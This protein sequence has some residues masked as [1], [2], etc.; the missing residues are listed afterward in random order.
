MLHAALSETAGAVAA[1]CRPD[2]A[3]ISRT[4][5][6][7]VTLPT[8]VLSLAPGQAWSGVLTEGDLCFIVGATGGSG[9]REFQTRDG[10][11]EPVIGVAVIPC[12]RQIDR[13]VAA[14]PQVANVTGGEEAVATFL[15]GEHLL[16]VPASDVTNAS[17]CPTRCARGAAASRSATSA[18]SS[19]TT[20]R[21]RS[22]TSPPTCPP[23]AP[24][25]ALVL[26]AGAQRFGL[27]VSELG[28]VAHMKLRG[29]TG[30]GE[31]TRLIAQLA[32]SGS[33]FIAVFA[34]TR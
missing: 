25:N 1:F 6:L 15:V 16:G 9:Y 5:E 7:P 13:E 30:R 20:W 23:P 11:V 4:G 34:P 14:A 33:V 2:G 21:C 3:T 18:S 29:L 22:W 32:R 26:K 10:Y 27:L 28:P 19:G 8:S 17:R 31:L 12:G 24:R